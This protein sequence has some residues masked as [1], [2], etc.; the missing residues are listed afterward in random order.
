KTFILKTEGPL[1]TGN[2]ISLC[3]LRIEISQRENVLLKP[4]LKEITPVYRDLRPY[5]V[6]VMNESEILAE[7]VR[8]IMTRNK[9]RD[10]YDLYFLIRKGVKPNIEFIH[11]KLHYYKEE[12]DT[13][14]FAAKLREKK[15]V[16]EKEMKRYVTHL[17]KFDDVFA[18][19]MKNMR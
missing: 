9:P 11:R 10:V 15:G 13:K 16:W 19:I 1:Y 3:S 12:Y 5:F 14:K 2:P 17:P 6:L 7:K 8:A 4:E 18:E